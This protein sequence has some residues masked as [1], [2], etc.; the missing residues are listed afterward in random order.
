LGS[1]NFAKTPKL[2]GKTYSVTPKQM[3]MHIL[4]MTWF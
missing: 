2:M 1:P 3:L 4:M